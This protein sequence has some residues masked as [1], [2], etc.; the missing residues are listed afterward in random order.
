MAAVI[1]GVEAGSKEVSG[2]LTPSHYLH[3]GLG[4]IC[5]FPTTLHPAHHPFA[6]VCIVLTAGREAAFSTQN[7][8]FVTHSLQ[9]G[10]LHSCLAVLRVTVTE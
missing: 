10:F 1:L 4:C 5:L 3:L 7:A 9:L 2:T 8:R 6:F